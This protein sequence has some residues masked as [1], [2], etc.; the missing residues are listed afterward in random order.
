MLSELE[1][2]TNLTHELL[3]CAQEQATGKLTIA[4]DSQ[5][6]APYHLFFHTGRLVYATGGDHPVRRWQR[7]WRQHCP[8]VVQGDWQ[9]QPRSPSDR[10]DMDLLNQWLEQQHVSVVTART[11]IRQLAQEILLAAIER[12]M[13][14]TTWQPDATVAQT[15][16]GLC[17]NQLIPVLMQLRASWQAIGLKPSDADSGQFL[18][19]LAPCIMHPSQLE[20][21]VSAEAFQTMSRLMQGN[22]TLWEVAQHMQRPLPTV[23]QALLP[24]LR[25]GLIDLRLIGDLP[26]PFTLASSA[27]PAAQTEVASLAAA[28][29]RLIACIDDSPA[30]VEAMRQ[31]LES[32]GYEVMTILNPLQGMAQLL[33]RKP[34]LI[35]LD[36]VMPNT[37][38]YELCS[39]LRKTSIFHHTPIVILTGHDGVIDRV[40]AQIAGASDFIAKPPEEKRVI[41][42]I[43][44]LLAASQAKRQ[45]A[46]ALN[47]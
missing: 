12:Q 11:I 43:E 36:L 19:D 10:W 37:N 38:G 15:A 42:A 41:S 8:T 44:R 14:T 31:L 28:R 20:A 21:Q 9:T 46:R 22:L 40:R 2:M 23:V 33:Q 32:Y 6:Y 17:V 13:A 34:D 27:Q 26:L 47:V 5:S 3:T 30:I 39:S 1:S 18:A 25:Q 4:D 45:D 29:A 24:L 7:L 35:F 16:A